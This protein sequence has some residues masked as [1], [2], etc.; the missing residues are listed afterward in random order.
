MFSNLINFIVQALQCPETLTMYFI[1]HE[2][3]KKTLSKVGY[4]SKRAEMFSTFVIRSTFDDRLSKYHWHNL[5]LIFLA[6]IF[7]HN[8]KI[9]KN[10]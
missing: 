10:Q 9:S 8:L 4:S 7:F 5:S 1:A 3:M 6:I 2:N